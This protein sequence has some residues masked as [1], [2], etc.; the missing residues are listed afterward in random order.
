MEPW[1]AAYLEAGEPTEEPDY[2]QQA[3]RLYAALPP[4]QQAGLTEILEQLGALVRYERRW[5]YR[6]GWTDAKRETPN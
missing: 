4:E 1:E 5:Y 2:T 6:R 3:L